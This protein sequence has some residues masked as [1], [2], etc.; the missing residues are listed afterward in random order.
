MKFLKYIISVR[1]SH[2]RYL[3]QVRTPLLPSL[4]LWC[5]VSRMAGHFSLTFCHQIQVKLSRR[6]QLEHD[7]ELRPSP[8][9]KVTDVPNNDFPHFML[10]T[11]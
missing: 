8:D 4:T 10:Y 1:G 9:A 7:T 11:L 5:S 2:C 6:K 3:P